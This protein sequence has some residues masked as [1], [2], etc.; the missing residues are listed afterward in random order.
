MREVPH[1]PGNMS[2]HVASLVD[3]APRDFI[4]GYF[5][6]GI[7]DRS[8]L[9]VIPPGV[10]LVTSDIV[11]KFVLWTLLPKSDMPLEMM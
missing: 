3:I 11:C 6:A 7:A 5:G 4:I 10:L 8:I 9:V 2:K 1:D